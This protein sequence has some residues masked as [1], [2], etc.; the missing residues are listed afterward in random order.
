MPTYNCTSE[1]LTWKSW[2][3]ESKEDKI[4]RHPDRRR[5]GKRLVDTHIVVE[6]GETMLYCVWE[7]E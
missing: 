2:E 7:S 3:C 6:N 4:N 1:D 5:D